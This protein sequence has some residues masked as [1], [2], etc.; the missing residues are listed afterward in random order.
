MLLFGISVGFSLQVS[1]SL[2]SHEHHGIMWTSD[3]YIKM[4][5][6]IKFTF[7][8]PLGVQQLE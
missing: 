4:C 5:L 1:K 2:S 7:S 3:R 8:L 6:C